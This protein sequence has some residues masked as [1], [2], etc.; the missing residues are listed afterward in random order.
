[1]KLSFR[2]YGLIT[3]ITS[4]NTEDFVVNDNYITVSSIKNHIENIY[5]ELK[6]V[7]FQIAVNNQILTADK[8][9]ENNEGEIALLPPFA[10]G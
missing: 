5:P 10:G 7:S 9:L 3:D 4:K 2:Y 6:K 1:M 8:I